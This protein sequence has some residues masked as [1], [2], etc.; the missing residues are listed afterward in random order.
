VISDP[1]TWSLP[2]SRRGDGSATLKLEDGSSIRIEPGHGLP[3]D[4]PL[5]YHRIETSTGHTQSII[6]VPTSCPDPPDRPEWGWAVQLY[7][8][9]SRESW[10]IG[11]LADLYGLNAWSA[12]A[13]AGFVLVNPLHA[14]SPGL[15]QQPSPYFPTSRVWRNPLYIRVEDISGANDVDLTEAVEAGRAL[16]ADRRIDR[17]RVWA[18]KRAALELVWDRLRSNTAT[19]SWKAFSRY[20][21]EQGQSL[22]DFATFCALMETHRSTWTDWTED[23]KRPTGLGAK[24]FAAAN[25]AHVG[26]HAFLQWAIDVQL[27]SAATTGI[28]LMTDLAIGVDRAGADAW[29]FQDCMALTTSVGAPPDEFATLGQNW[30]LPPFDPWKL[31]DA[32][33]EPFVQT[34]RSALRHAGALRMDHVMGLFRLWCIPEGAG[35]SEGAYVYLPFW[36]L[37]GIVSLEATRAGAYVVGEDLGTV[38]PYVREELASRKILSYRL[39]QFESVPASELP[40]TAMS[41][42]TTHDLA[43]MAG[44]WTGTDLV[45]QARAGTRPNV[46][47]T[48]A[49]RASMA[50][51]AG[52][53]LPDGQAG[54][55]ALVAPV[56]PVDAT[57][58]RALLND[59]TGGPDTLARVGDAVGMSTDEVTQSLD[60]AVS[61][62]RT[63]HGAGVASFIEAIHAELASAP[64]VLIA[65]TVDDAI[66]VE[67]RPNL[68][69][70][71]DEWPNW[72]IALPVPLEDVLADPRTA[73]LAQTLQR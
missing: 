2:P 9:R 10:G 22:E 69:G 50:K 23:L 8:A 47:G 27:A 5:G 26:F 67:E 49:M 52:H 39:T 3:S 66:A 57:T 14:A 38:E 51:R 32:G 15:G 11:D 72:R 58:V 62:L 60:R 37:L 20:R 41:A 73:R 34:V 45:E 48:I 33:Y 46:N 24:R 6:C 12:S 55:D 44:L 35:A 13:G 1:T 64:S 19:S 43:T 7:A 54:L 53:E 17:D 68:P 70:T 65:A 18:V 21:A 71:I 63:G 30:G 56:D 29:A 25:A 61:A 31:R 28:S 40:V 16:N 59:P 4:L 36:D 42:A